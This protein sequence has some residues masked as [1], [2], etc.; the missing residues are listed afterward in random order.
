[1]TGTP[2]GKIPQGTNP[3]STHFFSSFLPRC[4]H[5]IL[6][7][8]GIGLYLTNLSLYQTNK[9]KLTISSDFTAASK[10]R[11]ARWHS[12]SPALPLAVRSGMFIDNTKSTFLRSTRKSAKRM[13][14]WSGSAE[15]NF[16]TSWSPTRTV[17]DG[18]SSPLLFC[19]LTTLS[20]ELETAELS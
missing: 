19:I 1:M 16:G 15:L 5:V 12:A 14:T 13:F 6:Y 2:L 9:P 20:T 17:G 11:C 4:I 3:T 8:V 10:S 18:V 7:Q